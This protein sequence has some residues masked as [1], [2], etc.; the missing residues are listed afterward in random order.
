MGT[1]LHIK[2]M[3]FKQNSH[4]FIDFILLKTKLHKRFKSTF[5]FYYY[6]GLKLL[7]N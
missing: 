3:H 5:F 6:E 1:S 7:K 4:V 2:T